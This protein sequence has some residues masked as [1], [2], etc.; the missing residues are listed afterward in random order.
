VL[1]YE[2]GDSPIPSLYG[3]D[4]RSSVVMIG[5]DGRIL[6]MGLHGGAIDLAVANALGR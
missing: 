3:A 6:A 4:A 5:P 1:E 2:T